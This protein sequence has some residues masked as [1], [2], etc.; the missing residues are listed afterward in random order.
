[1]SIFFSSQ[2]LSYYEAIMA[3]ILSLIFPS[4]FDMH[5]NFGKHSEDMKSLLLHTQTTGN[6][7]QEK[8]ISL[9]FNFRNSSEP[10]NARYL[11]PYE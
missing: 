5:S 3:I 10:W 4:F 1:V 7:Q 9:D 6:N 8:C 11:E 2:K